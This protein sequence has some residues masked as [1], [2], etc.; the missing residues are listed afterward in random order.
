VPD[1][2]RLVLARDYGLE[3]TF[4]ALDTSLEGL[5]Y[6]LDDAFFVPLAGFGAVTRPGPNLAMHV[7]RAVSR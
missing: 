4:I 6:D 5:A 3:Q 2:L 7:R 1:A